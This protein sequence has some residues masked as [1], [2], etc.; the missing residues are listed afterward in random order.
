MKAASCD[1]QVGQQQAVCELVAHAADEQ[2]AAAEERREGGV[3][4]DVDGL[5]QPLPDVAWP[6]LADGRLPLTSYIKVGQLSLLHCKNPQ[7]TFH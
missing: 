6:P 7:G 4:T 5:P 3:V 1:G 2:A